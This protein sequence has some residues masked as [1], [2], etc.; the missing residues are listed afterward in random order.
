MWQIY[1]TKQAEKD[2]KKLKQAGLEERAKK[3][4]NLIA[5][6]PLQTPPACEK[7]VGDLKGYYSRRINIQHRLV[8]RIDHEE[9]AII[10]HAMWTHYE[11]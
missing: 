1:F 7:L 3:L 4:L 6:D 5:Q 10:I 11:N 2:K 9:H 8:Y